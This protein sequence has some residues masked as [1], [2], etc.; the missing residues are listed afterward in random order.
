M[1]GMQKHEG[2]NARDGKELAFLLLGGLGDHKRREKFSSKIIYCSN[3]SNLG[4]KVK[5]KSFYFIL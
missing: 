4:R 3:L 1:F 5:N 2:K